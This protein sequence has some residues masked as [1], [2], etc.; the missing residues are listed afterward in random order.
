MTG[1]EPSGPADHQAQARDRVAPAGC[2]GGVRAHATKVLQPS[3]MVVGPRMASKLSQAVHEC[4][5]WSLGPQ[6]GRGETGPGKTQG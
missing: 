2:V 3:P 1:R 5:L 6:R 4:R